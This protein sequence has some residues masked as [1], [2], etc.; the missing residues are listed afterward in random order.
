MKKILLT[1]LF[2]LPINL[3]FADH[4]TK[5]GVFKDDPVYHND[6]KIILNCRYGETEE[7]NVILDINGDTAKVYNINKSEVYYFNDLE[8]EDPNMEYK[9]GSDWS[10]LWIGGYI[11]IEFNTLRINYG[12][13][14][15]D[16]VLKSDDLY[17]PCFEIKEV[18]TANIKKRYN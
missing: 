6:K 10:I 12:Y 11:A 9:G 5:E 14:S 13:A 15:K 4:I 16:E 2:F 3:S 17:G 1:L 7:F 18:K 8:I